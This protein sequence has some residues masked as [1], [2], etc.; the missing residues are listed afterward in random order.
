[1]LVATISYHDN[2]NVSTRFKYS[3]ELSRAYAGWKSNWFYLEN[4]Y[5]KKQTNKQNK[6]EN[7]TIFES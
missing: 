4:T 3:Q 1:M 2:K 6:K 7:W 5:F